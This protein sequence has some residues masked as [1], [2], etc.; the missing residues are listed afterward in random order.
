M[1]ST[2]VWRVA[3]I[4]ALAGASLVAALLIS[5]AELTNGLAIVLWVSAVIL[6]AEEFFDGVRRRHPRAPRSKVQRAWRAIGCAST[7]VMVT[8]LL[9]LNASWT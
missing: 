5:G 2:I 6:I 4:A 9:V 1:N 8:A 7:L 3:S